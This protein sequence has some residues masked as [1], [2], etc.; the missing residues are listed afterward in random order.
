VGPA[1]VPLFDEPF[2]DEVT[3]RGV[4]E[5]ALALHASANAVE[6]DAGFALDQP[7]GFFHQV[8]GPEVDVGAVGLVVSGGSSLMLTPP[9]GNDRAC[10]RATWPTI[11]FSKP[12]AC[13]ALPTS[14]GADFITATRALV[15]CSMTELIHCD[16]RRLI[17]LPDVRDQLYQ[18]DPS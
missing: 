7:R 13:V 10:S 5:S 17:L 8:G 14:F 12:I 2:G 1:L 6:V 4:H 11:A 9:S 15:V 3:Q 18:P 16:P